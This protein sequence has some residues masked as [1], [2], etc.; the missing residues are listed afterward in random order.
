M[1][2]SADTVQQTLKGK[3]LQLPDYAVIF[4][5]DFP[6]YH[7]EF[8]GSVLAELT[9]EGT[10]MK[11]AQGIYV[12]PAI[13]RFGPV[14]PSV[15]SIVEAIAARDHAEVMPAGVTALNAL[16]LSTQ[17]PM[18]YVYL[19]S[20]SRRVIKMKDTTVILKTAVPKYFSYETKLIAMLVQA[21][22]TLKEECVEQEHLQ[23]IAMLLTKEPD[24]EALA[25]DILRMPAWMKRL[26]KPMM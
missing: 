3:I 26:V 7:A 23:Q 24:K 10:L 5:S 25:R 9:K 6:D 16:G 12:K 1:D 2:K 13:S 18:K 14:T 21:L 19:T 4:R 8:V 22:K 20:G 11:V 15:N 17:I